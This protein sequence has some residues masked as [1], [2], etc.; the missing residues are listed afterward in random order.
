M[1]AYPGSRVITFIKINIMEK[2]WQLPHEIIDIYSQET[3]VTETE[4]T[5]C[6]NTGGL[7][8]IAI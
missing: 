3:Q 6:E 1:G 5:E 7:L 4:P 8:V 2:L